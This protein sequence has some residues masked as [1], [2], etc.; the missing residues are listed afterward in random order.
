MCMLANM[1]QISYCAKELSHQQDA[2]DIVLNYIECMLTSAGSIHVM[3]LSG[4]RA[5]R[6]RS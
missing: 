5:G 6:L 2:K 4:V 1:S 3:M